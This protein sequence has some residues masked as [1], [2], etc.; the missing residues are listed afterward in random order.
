MQKLTDSA[1][2]KLQSKDKAYYVCDGNGLNISVMPNGIKYWIVRYSVD[3]KERKT[4]LGKFPDIS[5]KEARE[6][7]AEMK[8]R[9]KGANLAKS[10]HDNINPLFC[11]IID[12]WLEKKMKPALSPKYVSKTM[13]R[14]NKYI[15]PALGNIGI[16]T[17]NSRTILD[18]CRKIE[19]NGTIDTAHR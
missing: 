18:L 2:K 4:S 12:E 7:T 17:I 3:K 13:M 1:I 8:K 15:L 9:V 16:N 10:A 5:L 14:V 11:H 6:R 19:S